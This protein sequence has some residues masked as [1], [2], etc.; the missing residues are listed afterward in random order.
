MKRAILIG[1]GVVLG[2]VFNAQAQTVTA[3]QRKSAGEVMAALVVWA[4]AVRDR[5]AK[6]LDLLFAEDAVI[7][8]YDGKVRG[9]NEEL[10]VLRP[11]PAVRTVSVVND[12]VGIKIFGDVA[13]VTAL[14]KMDFIANEKGSSVSLRYT[15]VFVKR[16]ERWQIVALQTA[17]APEP[18]RG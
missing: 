4:D 16:D 3:E 15:A 7:T 14:T 17:R 1:F 13:V 6:R 8:T 2:F 11:D 9:K 12:D 10:D 18:A 5:D